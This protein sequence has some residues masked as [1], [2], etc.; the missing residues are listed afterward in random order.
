MGGV[1]H[2]VRICESLETFLGLADFGVVDRTV[3]KIVQA[4]K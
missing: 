4:E 1:L 3:Q 2:K